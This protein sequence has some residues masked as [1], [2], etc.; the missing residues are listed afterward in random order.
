MSAD[1]II[2]VLVEIFLKNEVKAT[3]KI[4]I[5]VSKN[6]KIELFVDKQKK[7][8]TSKPSRSSHRKTRRHRKISRWESKW[9]AM[10][11]CE[12]FFKILILNNFKLTTSKIERS[13]Q[14]TYENTYK[15]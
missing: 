7:N 2:W 12:A 15:T 4:K 6:L 1:D 5:K 11:H 8:L 9:H 13:K 10:I 3:Y 14:E